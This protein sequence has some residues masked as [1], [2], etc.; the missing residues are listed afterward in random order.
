MPIPVASPAPYAPLNAI[1]FSQPDLSVSPVSDGNPLP[2]RMAAQPASA[3]LAGDAS[4]TVQVGPY[5]SVAG[6][7]VILSLAG[8]W[9][10]SVRVLRST[11]GGITRLPLTAAGLAWGQFTANCCEPVWEESVPGSTLYLDI[12][13]SSG[14]VTYRMEQ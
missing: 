5:A 2:V 7:P 6:S 9:V 1:G 4:G 10:G 8:T 11:N 3:A 12:T 13:L 14:T